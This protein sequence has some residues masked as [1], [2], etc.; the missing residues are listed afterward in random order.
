MPDAAN[1]ESLTKHLCPALYRP[2]FRTPVTFRQGRAYGNYM[3]TLKMV[4][5]S[6]AAT[7]LAGGL[8]VAGV[9]AAYGT[10]QDG[11]V[12]GGLLARAK[13][14]LGLTSDQVAQIKAVFRA[15]KDILTPLLTKL[16]D[17]RAD[18]RAATQAPGATEA[19]VRTASAKVAAVEADLAVE[20]MSLYG[21]ISPI[22]T[23]EQH[24]QLNQMQARM[25]DF[26]DGIISRVS[27]RLAE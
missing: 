5:L 18:L 17:A 10:E 21:R 12:R 1:P 9:H 25:D 16:H 22:L 15:D 2:L 26:V 11:P 6:L 27:E 4:S 24:E 8:L 3:K 14:K 19:S 23:A 13:Q 7:V 20:R